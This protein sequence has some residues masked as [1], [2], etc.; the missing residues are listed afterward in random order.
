MPRP[1]ITLLSLFVASLALAAGWTPMN[2]TRFTLQPESRFWIEGTSSL[3]AWTCEVRQVD[4]FIDAEAAPAPRVAAA[5]VS[6]AVAE[7][8]CKN[9][10]MDKKTRKALKAED[11][12]TIRYVLE[13]AQSLGTGTDGWFELKTTGRLAMA[14]AERSLAMTVRGQALP[15]GGFRFVGRTPL[16]MTDFGVD[17]PTALLGTLKT[18]D[19]VVVRFDV[20]VAR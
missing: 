3:H 8:A 20:T 4:G 12:P 6:V 10:T 5:E 11:H 14:G 13:S 19:E 18:G 9:G 17:P 16:R 15:D 7:I 2:P 1:R